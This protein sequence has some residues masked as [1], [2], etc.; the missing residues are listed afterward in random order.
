MLAGKLGVRSFPTFIR[1]NRESIAA[2]IVGTRS[3]DTYVS[4]LSG[5]LNKEVQATPQPLLATLLEKEHL[6]FVKE[7]EVMYDVEQTNFQGFVGSQLPAGSYEQHE[8]LGETNFIKRAVFVKI[9]DK[10]IKSIL[11]IV[12][13]SNVELSLKALFPLMKPLWDKN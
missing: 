7:I 11:T 9:V 8:L 3:L 12:A 1:V 2:K 4:G 5:I 10:I 13:I 6:L